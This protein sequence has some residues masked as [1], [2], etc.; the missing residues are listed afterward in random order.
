MPNLPKDVERYVREAKEA[1][2]GIDEGKAWA[3]AWSRFC[4]YKSPGDDHCKQGPEGYFK[5]KK[6]M[7]SM[8]SDARIDRLA[9][10]VIERMQG[11]LPPPR[12]PAAREMILHPPSG[13][14][15]HKNKQDFDRGHARAPKHKNR[16]EARDNTRDAGLTLEESWGD[17]AWK[18]L[19]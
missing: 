12:S 8:F 19:D 5:G 9:A 15:K 18:G 16:D 3:I 2:P 6:A 11:K 14:G 1:D 13:G 17:F 10:K 7:S 4:K